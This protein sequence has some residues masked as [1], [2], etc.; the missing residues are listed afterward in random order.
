GAV[1]LNLTALVACPGCPGCFVF[2]SGVAVPARSASNPLPLKS[3]FSSPSRP[4]PETVTSTV[5][6]AFAPGGNTVN[7]CSPVCP[8]APP[9]A[10]S[11]T[12]PAARRRVNMVASSGKHAP[13]VQPNP[14]S[15]GQQ[16]CGW[17]MMHVALHS[18]R[19]SIHACVATAAPG[20]GCGRVGASG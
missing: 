5:A 2:G 14:D 8:A 6:P 15:C 10:R 1:T 13:E 19:G 18:P 12:T 20:P 4:T 9:H 11:K 3:N 16:A 7:S 17:G